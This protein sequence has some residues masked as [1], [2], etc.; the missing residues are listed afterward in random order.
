M[1]RYPLHGLYAITDS[2]L[3][4]DDATLLHAVCQALQGGANLVQYRDK[5]TDS[6]KRL[7]QARA[8]VEL[9]E[10]YQVP[11]LIND[12]IEL[13]ILSGAAGVHLGQSDGNHAQA[14]TQLGPEAIIGIT[15]HDSLT[16]AQQAVTNNVDYIA[17]GAFFTSSTKP[18]ASPAPLSIL[19]EARTRFALPIVA[20][21]GISVDN[22][23]QVIEAGADMVAVIHSL[24]TA[25]DISHRAQTFKDQFPTPA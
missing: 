18:D 15:C 12:D 8:L 10:Q 24:F 19:H 6:V 2:S 11:L 9:C 3:M 22:A 7:R 23:R 13:A 1:P 17:F 20:I 21:G 16:L 14:R 5:S 25:D 4:P